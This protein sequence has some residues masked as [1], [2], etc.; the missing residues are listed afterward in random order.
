V[1]PYFELEFPSSLAGWMPLAAFTD[2]QVLHRRAAAVLAALG[3]GPVRAA[4]S[5]DFLGMA[6]RVLSPAVAA[7]A[8][9]GRTDV[10][11]LD[12]VWWRDRVPGPLRLAVT[13][14]DT[15]TDLDSAVV[16]PVLLPL[17]EAYAATFS[18]S[19]TV[20]R[21]N[22]ESARNTAEVIVGVRSPGFMRDS[23]CLIYRFPNTG[24]WG[25]CVLRRR[26]VSGRLRSAE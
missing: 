19:R 24:W 8:R 2:P 23:C 18:L 10:L 25:D 15:A 26:S 9:S 12:T 16:Q 14:T 6:A 20:L 3:D 4:A 17:L 7:L 22:V 11:T 13:A 21:G 1:N 5:V